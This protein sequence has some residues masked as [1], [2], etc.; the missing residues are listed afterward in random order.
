MAGWHYWLDGRQSGW[1]PGVGDGQGGLACCDSWGHKESDTTEW[2]N[3]TELW[4]WES[5]MVTR[6]INRFL[7]TVIWYMERK[8]AN[9]K[10]CSSGFSDN[11]RRRNFEIRVLFPIL[12]W[13]SSTCWFFLFD[14][15][16]SYCGSCTSLRF[17]FL[18]VW[19]LMIL[20]LFSCV[21]WPC[22][23]LP[24]EKMSIEGPLPTFNMVVYLFI[25]IEL[26]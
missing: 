19:R 7:S 1:T 17:W 14:N 4:R 2:L 5:L 11:C 15:S 10:C 18:F 25:L 12:M 6:I 23:Y 16:L 22:V 3:W 8:C 20:S 26:T 9:M 13:P 24:W 21:C